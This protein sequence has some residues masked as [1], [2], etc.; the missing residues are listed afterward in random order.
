MTDVGPLDWGAFALLVAL[1]LLVDLRTGAR[2][3]SSM[4]RALT[5]SAMWIG[6]AFMFGLFVLVRFGGD[7]ASTY[8][9]AWLVE[10]SLSVDNLFAFA[11]VFGELAIPKRLQHRLLFLGV[12]GAL[13]G[14]ALMLA[15]GIQLIE[16]LSAVIYVFAALL[17]LAALRILFGQKAE[18]RVI[19]A[20]CAVCSTCIARFIPVTANI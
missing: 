10:K 1:L 13:V 11:L 14:R 7:S 18:E 15:L 4:R 6:L 12:L 8:Y 2:A 20:S 19:K 16:Q 9:A 3:A 17:L 5:W